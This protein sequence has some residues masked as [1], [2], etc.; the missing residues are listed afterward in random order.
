[1][2]KGELKWEEIPMVFTY[3]TMMNNF[4]LRRNVK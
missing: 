2:Y 4:E 3:Q 1:M